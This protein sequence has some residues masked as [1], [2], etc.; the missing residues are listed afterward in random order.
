MRRMRRMRRRTRMRGQAC[1]GF[2]SHRDRQTINRTGWMER[3]GAEREP[4]GVEERCAIVDSPAI[5]G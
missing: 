4:W 1:S 3:E 2:V 5:G